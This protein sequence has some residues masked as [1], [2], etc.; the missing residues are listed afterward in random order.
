MTVKPLEH[1]NCACF[2]IRKA[3]RKITQAYDWHLKPTG[4]QATQFTLL[5]MLSANDDKNGIAMTNLAKRLGMDRTTL[6][7]NLTLA[8]RADWVTITSG[9]DRRERL[10]TLTPAGRRIIKEAEPYWQAA[11]N[12]I[13]KQ[14]GRTRLSQ[15]I[16]LTRSIEDV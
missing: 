8:E 11:Q 10:I 3:A 6:T 1:P 4:L 16:E 5:A 9:N 15:L 13:V 7:R 2:N 12:Q 14:L